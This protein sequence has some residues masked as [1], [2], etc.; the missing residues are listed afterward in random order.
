MAAAQL[1]SGDISGGR[2][3]YDRVENEYGL[4]G[5]QNDA[6][7]CDVYRSVI[8]ILLQE[9]RESFLCPA[10]RDPEWKQSPNW[11]KDNP[12]TVDVDESQPPTSSSSEASTGNPEESTTSSG[13]G[14]G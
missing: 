3:F 12:L 6:R 10:G 5:L 2:A 1:C 14:A 13:D 7:V 4:V 11:V 9:P 8:S